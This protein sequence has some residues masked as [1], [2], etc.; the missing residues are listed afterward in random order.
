MPVVSLVSGA[1]Q[2]SRSQ[3]G[4]VAITMSAFVS[5]SHDHRIE[6]RWIF[7]VRH[8]PRHVGEIAIRLCVRPKY[9][10]I[11][12]T[13]GDDARITAEVPTP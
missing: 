2:P 12:K 8:V 10:H 9:F 11:G 4:S 13:V 3:S 6:H 1:A 5:L 7:G